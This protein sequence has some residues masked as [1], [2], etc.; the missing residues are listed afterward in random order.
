[1]QGLLIVD[2]ARPVK[3]KLVILGALLLLGGLG[4]GHDR[5]PLL[6]VGDLG[7]ES[8]AS[9]RHV[10]LG[11]GHMAGEP[12]EEIRARHI[13]KRIAEADVAPV[14]DAPFAV[15]RDDDVRGVEVA[16]AESLAARHTLKPHVEIVARLLGENGRGNLLVELLGEIAHALG[17]LGEDLA[18]DGHE[19]LEVAHKVLLVAGHG[20]G[21]GLALHPLAADAPLVT[22]LEHLEDSRHG[23]PRLGGASLVH[24]LVEDGADLVARPEDL[25]NGILIA[26]NDL[27]GT[28][29]KDIS[30]LLGALGSLGSFGSLGSLLGCLDFLLLNLNFSFLSHFGKPF[31]LSS[32]YASDGLVL[33]VVSVKIHLLHFLH[34]RIAR[35][36]ASAL[37]VK[38][39]LN[40]IVETC[41]E[42]LLVRDVVANGELD[43]DALAKIPQGRE[44]VLELLALRAALDAESRSDFEVALEGVGIA[45]LREGTHLAR[46]GIGVEA[47]DFLHHERVGDT[48]R[49]VVEGAE[50]VGHRVH[51]AEERVRKR[52]AG[53]RGGVG[54]P[55]AGHGIGALGDGRIVAG[56]EVL[57]DRLESADGKTVRVVR[58]EHR[59]VGLESMGDGVNT[60]G[61]RKAGRRRHLHIGIDDGHRG[62]KLVIGQRI[63]HA[64]GLVRDDGEGR[65]FRAGTRRGGH[66]DEGSLLAHLGERVDAL[67][68]I[69]EAHGHV[70]EVHLGVL[71][72][73]P[74]DLGCVHGAAAADGD[75]DVRLEAGHKLGALLGAGERRIGGDVC[76][77]REGNALLGEGLL[78]HAGVAVG[79][80]EG[81]R[82]DERALLAHDLAQFAK[83][84]REAALLLVDLLRAAE[85]QHVFSSHCNSLNIDQVFNAD[86][87]GDGVAAPAAA[88]KRERG[89]EH[90]VVDITDTALRARSVDENAARLHARSELAELGLLVHLVEVD[91]AGV[92]VAAVRNELLSLGERVLNVLRA[93]HRENGRELLV[94]ELLGKFHALDLANEN[95]RVGINVEAGE[96]SDRDRLL[97]DDLG[98]ERAVDENRL[99]G[100]V[101]LGGVEEVA[102]HL[103]EESLDLVV[104]GIKD[105][106]ALLGGADHAVVERLGMDN[107]ADGEREIGRLVDDGGGVACAHAESGGAGAVGRLDH[108]GA[109][110]GEDEVRLLHEEVRLGERRSLDPA[111]DALRSARFDGRVE[112][113]LG[114]SD[115]SI[116]GARVGADDNA[117]TGLERDERLEDGRGGGVCGGDYRADNAHGLGDLLDAGRLVALY[118]AAGL[119]VLKCVVDVFGGVVVLDDLVLH[120]AHAGLLYGHLG[121]RDARTVGGEG[122]SLEDRIDLLL[123]IGRED[124]LRRSN[125]RN[126]F[127]EFRKSV[128][129]DGRGGVCALHISF[130]LNF[131]KARKPLP[132]IGK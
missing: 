105:D 126:G 113:D 53:D 110:R 74:H 22:D 132:S 129:L 120:N 16:M 96:L 54:H 2:H 86:V 119:G 21:K 95:L 101:K 75:D 62:H 104:D 106:H 14:D 28:L 68:D 124:F 99:A 121:E 92:A 87:L 90:E 56:R 76:E 115:S 11:G 17:S 35:V 1:M 9:D 108:A 109:A 123:G 60:G 48:V 8:L 97:T 71:V 19:L 83:R 127:G 111:D 81:V 89:S 79:I 82:H 37:V 131:L 41:E 85:P 51:D 49:N 32:L 94:S 61:A 55:L 33:A 80:E 118:D 18:L 57:E 88:T 67:A 36:G 102:S 34:E 6:D 4:S 98:V 29:E 39:L 73:N 125:A 24:R 100:L 107:R 65:D 42:V 64:G 77:S 43:A 63:L 128:I 3:E 13:G 66:A 72:E 130:F 20:L 50:L 69:H 91:R 5:E 116:L 31:L 93:I 30:A 40:H 122:R 25:E 38:G 46:H 23:K 59:S 15:G 52:H 84:E 45:V 78:D 10:L 12:E 44:E 47:D 7:L 114:R 103:A 26:R 112:H 58:S 27:V 70:H 117:V